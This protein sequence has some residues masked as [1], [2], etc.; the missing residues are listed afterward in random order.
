M[1][2]L[3]TDTE[4]DEPLLRRLMPAI[5]HTYR[6]DYDA[7]SRSTTAYPGYFDDE[8]TVHAVHKA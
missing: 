7:D 4:V 2:V 3:S 5:S 6:L 1:I 8:E